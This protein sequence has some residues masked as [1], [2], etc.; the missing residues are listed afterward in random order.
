MSFRSKTQRG[1]YLGQLLGTKS[2]FTS[3]APGSFE[4][5][6]SSLEKTEKP[7]AYALTADAK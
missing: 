6:D 5:L 1:I 2:R 4:T 7:S 3:R